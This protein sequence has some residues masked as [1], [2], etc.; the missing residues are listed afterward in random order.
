[1]RYLR[2]TQV[3]K[4]KTVRYAEDFFKKML[5]RRI[6][7][8]LWARKTKPENCLGTRVKSLR[9]KD[10]NHVLSADNLFLY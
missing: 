4:E 8:Y 1:M 6:K 5:C 7:M 9:G 3:V 2:F 10:K